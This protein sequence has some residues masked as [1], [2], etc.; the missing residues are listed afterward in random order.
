M[1]C[2]LPMHACM[3]VFR[4]GPIYFIT[5]VFFVFFILINVFLAIINDSYTKVKED[6]DRGENSFEVCGF[7]ARFHHF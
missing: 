4:F 5:Y 7:L 6:L 1:V 2:P 3:S